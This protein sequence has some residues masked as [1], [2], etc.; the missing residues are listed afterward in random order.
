MKNLIYIVAIILLGSCASQKRC[1]QKYPVV[2]EVIRHD[3]VVYRD[4]IIF[5]D[6]VIY[7][8]IR[9]DTVFAEG[10]IKIIRDAP[11]SDTV[12]AENDYAIAKAWIEAR[13]L[14]LQLEQKGQVIDKILKNAE[15]ETIHWKEEY[16]SLEQTK[17]TVERYIPKVYKASFWILIILV[18]LSVGFAYLKIK[19][20]ILKNL[21]K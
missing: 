6:R 7:D 15:K 21:S 13:K 4:T 16:H 5:R 14:K 11:I 17:V 1:A 9:P 20:N 2:A 8:T 12:R 18:I 3:S 10:K 19:T